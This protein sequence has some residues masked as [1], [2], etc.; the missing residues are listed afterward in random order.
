MERIPCKGADASK[1]FG[2]LF[3]QSTKWMI[4]AVLVQILALVFC[5]DQLEAGWT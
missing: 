4:C 2:A 5:S 1:Q 3:D